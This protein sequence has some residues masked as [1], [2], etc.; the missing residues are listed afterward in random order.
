MKAMTPAQRDLLIRELGQKLNLP[1][2]MGLVEML[3]ESLEIYRRNFAI[4]FGLALVPALFGTV[5]GMIASLP[6]MLPTEPI[7]IALMVLA[8]LLLLFTSVVG[9][10]AQIWAAGQA[11][12]G[13]PIGFGEAWMAVL[14]RLGALILTM[15]IAFFPMIAGLALCCIGIL[16]TVVIFFAV[17]EQ[18]IL[19]E[20]LSYLRAIKRHIQLVLPNW[21]WLRVL[22]YY[23]ASSL[24][25]TIVSMLIGWGGMV[26]VLG[27]EIGREVLPLPTRVSLLVAGQ[28][29]QQ[30]TNALI[31]P[32]WGVFMTLL[33]FDLRARRE[34]YD[35]QVLIENWE[36]MS[37]NRN[38]KWH[39]Q[40]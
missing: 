35:L 33:Y 14:K 29:W 20:G 1:Y 15:L 6:Q 16:F 7:Y 34:A 17:L 31:M 13:K 24:F 36:T 22:I 23:L 12:M 21:E 10:G 32:Y 2:P 26:S 40:L 11:I 39:H 37:T 28:I 30:L 25:I 8:Y 38:P 3:E 5:F 9:Y 27:V 19:L 18:I 4:L